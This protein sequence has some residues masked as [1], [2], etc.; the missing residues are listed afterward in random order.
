MRMHAVARKAG[1]KRQS[2]RSPDKKHR[3]DL[4]YGICHF[5]FRMAVKAGMRF[6]VF[7]D[8]SCKP[9]GVN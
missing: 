6:L 7:L 4:S 9:R 3:G 2:L 1:T 5:L 8:V